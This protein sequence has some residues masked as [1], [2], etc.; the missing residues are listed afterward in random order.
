MK[1]LVLS[2]FAL[3]LAASP[4]MAEI[5]RE[6]PGYP[7]WTWDTL[8]VGL[9]FSKRQ[10]FTAE[11]LKFLSRFPLFCVE[12]HQGIS[13]Y[14]DVRRGA[15]EV[16]KQIKK[17]NP[18][19]KILFY[20]NS[21][22]DT[23]KNYF[24]ANVLDKTHP[25]WALKDDVG[26]LILTRGSQKNWDTRIPELRSWWVSIP[27]TAVKK[28]GMDGTFIDAVQQHLSTK[29]GKNFSAKSAEDVKE[30][31]T[32]MLAELR[33]KVGHDKIILYNNMNAGKDHGTGLSQYA[34]GGMIEHYC[35]RPSYTP[36]SLIEQIEAVQEAGRQGRIIMPKTWPRYDYR[37]P[38]G[39]AGLTSST[40][41]SHCKEDINYALSCF[42]IG[43][44]KYAYFCYSYGY[45]EKH[46]N[47]FDYPEY[48]YPLGEPEGEAVRDGFKFTRKFKYADVYL[49][50]QT[51]EHKITWH[52]KNEFKQSDLSMPENTFESKRSSG[53]NNEQRKAN[54]KAKNN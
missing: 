5:D 23:G 52:R 13:N 40:I 6:H 26:A 48:H 42:L 34:D 32:L 39:F 54:R 25:E 31:L 11:E 33:E 45:S 9:H 43:A 46:G 38:E 20:W 1:K 47:Y 7:E 3:L 36:E 44:G 49:D 30:G 4:L 53:N 35:D 16:K 19:A 29:Q 50:V 15:Y 24:G 37:K 8:Q 51:R 27:E 2:I 41:Y 22:I 10:N 28:G 18:K 21:R 17:Y 12:K 14:G